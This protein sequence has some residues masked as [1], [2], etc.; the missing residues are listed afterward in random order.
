MVPLYLRSTL[1]KLTTMKSN[2]M[3]LVR[4][5]F[6]KDCEQAINNQINLE[7]F[8]SYVY[9]S[10]AYYFDRCDV[11][12]PGH[13]TYFKK[14]SDEEREHAMKFMTYQNK[15]GGSITLT[16]I[17]NPPKNDWISAYDAMTEAL[18]LERQV[19]EILNT[20]SFK[21]GCNSVVECPLRMR[22]VLGSNPSS[23]NLN[24][25]FFFFINL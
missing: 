5:N 22:K 20:L 3:D 24:F 1:T 2:I 11:A 21:W 4:Q 19:N 15:R 16:P 23:S 9:L 18:K 17:E 8:S 25:F 13:Y 12:L 14:A 6:H 10:M 7:L